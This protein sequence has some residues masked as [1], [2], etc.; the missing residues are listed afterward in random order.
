MQHANMVIPHIRPPCHA[1]T[2]FCV[3]DLHAITVPHD[4]ADLR[5]STR[6]MAAT[7]LAAG[8]DPKRVRGMQGFKQAPTHS[9]SHILPTLP[10]LPQSTVFVQSHVSAHAEL[11]W[12]L[13]CVTPIGWL[14]RM[15]QF[16]EKSRKQ[17]EEVRAGLLTYPVLMAA[18][19]L[20][21]QVGHRG[22]AQGGGRATG[23]A[24]Q[25]LRVPSSCS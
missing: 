14:N 8:I 3:V 12:L 22:A 24:P 6:T 11:Q 23:C 16:K 15:I 1:D 9:H 7:Y 21:Y 4:P 10:L 13:N 5:S 2:F 17:G 19:I 25:H 18:D 20:L